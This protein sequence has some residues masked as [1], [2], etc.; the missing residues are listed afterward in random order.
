MEAKS[1]VIL[2]CLLDLCPETQELRRNVN[3]HSF[4]NFSFQALDPQQLQTCPFKRNVKRKNF[5]YVNRSLSE[6]RDNSSG[7][8]IKALERVGVLEWSDPEDDE[9]PEKYIAIM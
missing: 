7:D 9:K 5:V 4:A 3:S 8:E 2:L 6:A 1:P